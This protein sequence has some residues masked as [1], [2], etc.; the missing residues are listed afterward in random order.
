MR[1]TTIT[2]LLAALYSATYVLA[3][4][5]QPAVTIPFESDE[6]APTPTNAPEVELVEDGAKLE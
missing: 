4:G 2:C 1:Y 5:L 6:A 3:E